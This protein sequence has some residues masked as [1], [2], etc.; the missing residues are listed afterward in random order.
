MNGV[1][2]RDRRGQEDCIAPGA[3]AT[4]ADAKSVIEGGIAARVWGQLW[5]FV[6]VLVLVLIVVWIVIGGRAEGRAGLALFLYRCRGGR[7]GG[8]CGGRRGRRGIGGRGQERGGVALGMGERGGGRTR[9]FDELDDLYVVLVRVVW[10]GVL[11]KGSGLV[12]GCGDVVVGEDDGGERG[13]VVEHR[14]GRWGDRTGGGD[15]VLAV[16]ERL[17]LSG[18]A[19]DGSSKHSGQIRSAPSFLDP[20][21]CKLATHAHPTPPAGPAWTS[22]ASRFPSC[23]SSSDANRFAAR[24]TFPIRAPCAD[25]RFDS[26]FEARSP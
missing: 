10:V 22:L 24:M 19:S 11:S 9:G 25:G 14:G 3:N 15:G 7:E 2:K 26:R 1:G 4:H 8:G 12:V 16:L 21:I 20:R 23:L 13:R 17:V 5:W 18:R 6:L